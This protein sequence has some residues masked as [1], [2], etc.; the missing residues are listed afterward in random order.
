VKS[1]ET[2]KPRNPLLVI[3]WAF[4][5]YVLVYTTQYVYVWVGS[6]VTGAGFGE[7]AGGE[8]KTYETV[9]LRGL[10]GLLLGVPATFLVVK[11]LWRRPWDW[12]RLRLHGRYVLLGAV[13]GAAVAVAAVAA[14]GAFGFARI[15]GFPGRFS[16]GQLVALLIGHLGWI[17]FTSI[18]EEPVFRGMVVREFAL[19]WGWPVATLLGGLYF[20]GIHL[21][22]IVPILTP[23]LIVTI[24]V[25][26]TAASALF[27]ALYV[28]SHSLWLPIG[29][30]A[31]WNFAL[32]P[33]LGA[34]MSGRARGFGLFRTVLSGPELLT[35]GEFGVEASVV[36]L[37]ITIVAAVCTLSIP[38]RCDL[39]SSRPPERDHGCEDDGCQQFADQ[40]ILC[41]DELRGA[42]SLTR[43]S[44]GLRAHLG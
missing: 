11:V 21:I 41:S 3:V 24:L 10:V 35:G 14:L 31:G 18:L 4:G 23:R 40:K 30:H 36:A 39:L 5:L 26:G 38:R 2:I 19:R 12:V 22:A 34:T 27:T 8:L 25:A 1:I 28:R 33:L 13:V 9:F 15:T 44:V 29:F 17:V 42:G 6:A 7:L 20:A 43:R 37:A 32:A 16:A